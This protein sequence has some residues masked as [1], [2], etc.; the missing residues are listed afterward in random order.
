M[1][2]KNLSSVSTQPAPDTR[3]QIPTDPRTNMRAKEQDNET[4]KAMR[5]GGIDQSKSGAVSNAGTPILTIFEHVHYALYKEAQPGTTCCKAQCTGEQT[6][7]QHLRWRTLACH[8]HSV[9]IFVIGFLSDFTHLPD[10]FDK[11]DCRFIMAMVFFH[12]I[13]R[14][15][16]SLSGREGRREG[17]VKR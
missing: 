10:F 3:Q 16:K 6:A 13:P 2:K 1:E 17:D 12:V 5:A 9:L 15:L 14:V 7:Q 8:S 11:F 4:R